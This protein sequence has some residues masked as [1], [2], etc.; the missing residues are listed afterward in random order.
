MINKTAKKIKERKMTKTYH[1]IFDAFGCNKDILHNERFIIEVLFEI[2][3][4]INMKVL[5]G[6]N[7][8]RDSDKINPGISAFEIIDTSHISIHTFTKTKEVYIDIFSCKKF[9]YE[10]IQNYLFT[11]LK[12]KPFQVQTLVVKYP[13]EK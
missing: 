12:V 7:L 1:I 5:S 4:L 10:K 13:Y 2:P 3:E 11:K 8:V 6:P 9:N